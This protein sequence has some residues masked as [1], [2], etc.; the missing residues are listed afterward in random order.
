MADCGLD[1]RVCGIGRDKVGETNGSRT[2]TNGTDSLAP[3]QV[4]ADRKA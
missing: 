3:H 4:L 2:A 1:L